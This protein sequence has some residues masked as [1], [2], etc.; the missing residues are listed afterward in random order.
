M[1]LYGASGLESSDRVPFRWLAWFVAGWLC[2]AGVSVHAAQPALLQLTGTQDQLPMAGHMVVLR[3]PTRLLS[4]TEAASRL[5]AD[6]FS[7]LAGNV[8]LGYTG[9]D[10][11]LA[12]RLRAPADPVLAHWL[13]IPPAVLDRVSLFARHAGDWKEE[14]IGDTLPF[15]GR[16]MP[17]PMA[18]FRLAPIGESLYLL[19][20]RTSSAM[21]ADPVIYGET[22]YLVHMQ[23]ALLGQGLFFGAL[24][25]VGLLSLVWWR[26][27][28]ETVYLL[29][30]AYLV[31]SGVALAAPMGL[32]VRYLHPENPAWSFYT[33]G[34][35]FLLA[36]ML[37]NLCFARILKTRR[38][39][40][41]AHRTIVLTNLLAGLGCLVMPFGGYG[42]LM[43]LVL[44]LSLVLIHW[45]PWVCWRQI[46]QR[47]LQLGYWFLAGLSVYSVGIDMNFLRL[48]GVLEPGELNHMLTVGAHL[49]QMVF[50][51]T[52]LAF[53]TLS[54]QQ[55]KTLAQ[56][57]RLSRARALSRRL[58]AQVD[59]RTRLL[60]EEISERQRTE[61]LLL[62]RE[63]QLKLSLT[64]KQRDLDEQRRFVAMLSH[65]LRT[66]MAVIDSASQMLSLRLP[67]S[68][69]SSQSRL[70]RIRQEVRRLTALC[71]NWLA[72]DRLGQQSQRLQPVCCTLA[73][74][75]QEVV[76]GIQC[77]S[78]DI[79]L[80]ELPVA[81]VVID[82]FLLRV[83]L[84]NL[85]DNARKYSPAGL[86]VE[87][88]AGCR[89]DGMLVLVVA[90]RGSGVPDAL[91]ETIFERYERGR[92][93][94]ASIRGLGLG[95]SI[96]RRIV[97]QH[98][99]QIHVRDRAGGGS[100][101]V[102]Q[103]PVVVST[104]PLSG[105]RLLPAPLMQEVP[106]R[107]PDRTG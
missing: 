15:S 67:A 82:P 107:Q 11:W 69:R 64:D 13:E 6:E 72:D 14:S 106:A 30:A 88:H 59:E 56:V 22:A 5:A 27:S 51:G 65:E 2:L 73:V 16:R 48:L 105:P 79:H 24:L 81:E 36:I 37:S 41:W 19:R 12:F 76:A 33:T 9:D 99:G 66:P 70:A 34:L 63:A 55:K 91:K 23:H 80:H 42:M 20:I 35:S 101:F 87:L 54:R 18:T 52:G 3:D 60:R 1:G 71:D 57:A 4:V 96:V 7:P 49:L 93:H 90:D 38:R 103:L 62:Q 8:S 89:P 100:E 85:I 40:P 84:H 25:L 17:V 68:D 104:V 43:P 47:R 86:P 28:R 97:E 75:L 95:L 21:Q 61:R 94:V 83:A 74:W 92:E 78:G 45:L 58:D 44:L 10:V 46:R 31:C 50:M 29:Y 26:A 98:Q 32:T 102:V 39:A 53:R 77:E